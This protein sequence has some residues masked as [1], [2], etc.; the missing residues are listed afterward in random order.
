[1]A[2]LSLRRLWTIY[3][4]LAAQQG[5]VISKRDQALEQAAFYAGARGVLKVLA[6]MLEAGDFEE[7]HATIRRQGRMLRK[8]QGRRRKPAMRH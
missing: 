7:L 3:K 2:T 1:V 8:I 6:H 5:L 4:R